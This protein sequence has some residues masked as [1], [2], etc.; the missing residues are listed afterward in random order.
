[1]FDLLGW[2]GERTPLNKRELDLLKDAIA[3]CEEYYKS[4]MCFDCR[5]K[6]KIKEFKNG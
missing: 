5:N 1:M 3:A 2:L 4:S 6:I